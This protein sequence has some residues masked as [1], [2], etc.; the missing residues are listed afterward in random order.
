MTMQ[1]SKLA[2]FTKDQLVRLTSALM[3]AVLSLLPLHFGRILIAY[4]RPVAVSV[5]A[6]TCAA[7]PEPSSSPRTYLWGSS[8]IGRADIVSANA[9]LAATCLLLLLLGELCTLAAGN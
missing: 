7:V 5:P 6:C 1:R 8:A 3:S 2:V 9:T 4:C